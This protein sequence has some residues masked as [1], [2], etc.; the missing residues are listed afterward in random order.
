MKYLMFFFFFFFFLMIRRPPR[1]TLFPY[2]TLFRSQG[3]APRPHHRGAEHQAA[4]AAPGTRARSPA[5]GAEEALRRR[6]RPPGR[7]PRVHGVPRP[8]KPEETLSAQEIDALMSAVRTGTVAVTPG[9]SRPSS[10]VVR[11][12]FRRPNRVSKEQ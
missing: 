6:P 10:D 1:S 4:R 5:R 11:Y 2:T 12:N 3:A 7:H 9:A 8:V